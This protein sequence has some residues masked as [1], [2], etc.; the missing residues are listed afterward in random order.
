MNEITQRIWWIV[1]AAVMA[2]ALIWTTVNAAQSGFWE[3]W[4]SALVRVATDD[5]TS[6]FP[7]EP[8]SE[9]VVDS[10][11]EVTEEEESDEE[12]ASEE[13]SSFVDSRAVPTLGGEPVGVSWV[14]TNAISAL[15]GGE[16]VVEASAIGSVE[17]RGR[18]P[19]LVIALLFVGSAA[20]WTRRFAGE[21]AAAAT[22]VVLVTT[23]IF[24]LGS[25]FLSG[26]LIYVAASTLAVMGFFQ[27][28]YGDQKW[29][30]PWAVA[31]GVSL[32]VVAL[33]ERLIGVYAVLAAVVALAVAQVAEGQKDDEGLDLVAIGVTAA[34]FVGAMV[35]GFSQ[36]KGFDEGLLRPDVAHKLWLM[37]PA[38]LLVGL[39]VASRRGR[40][41]EAICSLRGVLFLAV[42]LAPLAILGSAYNAAVPADPELVESTIPV[43]NYLLENHN[44]GEEVTA[45]GNFAW[46]WRQVGFGLFPHIMFV[47][48]ALGY[49]AWKLRP[50]AK[51]SESERALAT[52][53]LVWPA[54]AFIV[55]APA[56]AMGHTAFP[57]FFAFVIALGWMVSDEEF[58]KTLRLRPMAYFAVAF[59]AIFVVM[60][61]AKDLENYPTRLVEF[62]LGGEE[63][64]GLP[65]DYEYGDLLSRWKYAVV[66]MLA[67]YFAGLVSW[68]VFTWRDGKRLKGWTQKKWRRW[69]KKE[70]SEDDQEQVQE[71]DEDRAPGELRMAEREQWR[72]EDGGLATIA[73]YGERLPGLLALI[74]ISGV[75]FMGA[76]FLSFTDDL[77]SRLSSRAVVEQYGA[78][79][80]DGEELFRYQISEQRENF[81]IHGLGEISNRRDFNAKYAEEERFFALIPEDRLA[82]THSAVRRAHQENIPVLASGGGILLVSNQLLEGEVDQN[83]ISEFV[84]D[85]LEEDAYIPLLV[86]EDD[87]EEEHPVFSR[88]IRF[89][90]YQLDRGSAEE[91]AV[92][93]WGDEMEITM[94]FEVLRRIPSSQEIFMHIDT[95]GNRIHG[96]HDP[97]GGTYPTNH[98]APGDIIKDV[99]QIEIERFSTPGTY[100]IRTGFY[101]GDD[102]MSVTPDEAH[103]GE[104]RV[105]VTQIQV[106]PF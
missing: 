47:V 48:P 99:H 13:V 31:A 59:V 3:P 75:G 86:G 82:V 43:L 92:Y 50:E 81:Y 11:E 56:A 30:L 84:F 67:T 104:D 26:P 74:I 25:I 16:S 45:A 37:G 10:E 72:D 61:L 98:W 33:D 32:A 60:I 38:I 15:V 106:E 71:Q 44:F 88:Q 36:S 55:V 54:A 7:E 103:D 105:D 73:R 22:A 12:S 52:L 14:K 24:Y 101:R 49:L 18:I 35:W 23:P 4:E 6:E 96:D 100:T 5:L 17:R 21:S 51:S 42:G 66:A 76:N 90:G 70:N 9:E 28:V 91:R 95:P 53:C 85:E 79:A 83:P 77:D 8:S 2:V 1:A 29:S 34:A 58:W 41:G 64:L 97:A 19:L 89:L 27:S 102:R 20:L 78:L 69:R 40:V 87:E 63:E 39:S 80:E 68:L 65:E 46:W 62:I 57:A 94:Y 93:R